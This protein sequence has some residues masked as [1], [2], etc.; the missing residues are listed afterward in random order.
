VGKG[1]LHWA[2][3]ND[4]RVVVMEAFNARN[5]RREDL[6]ETVGLGAIDVSFISLTKIL[7]AV[8]HVLAPRA[9]V[10]TLIKP[11][12]EAGRKEV[13]KGGVVRDASVRQRVVEDVRAFGCRETGLNWIGVRPSPL[14][15][16]A[17]NVEF[18]ALWEY[19][20]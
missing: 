8:T 19:H 4:P 15:G 18:L 6:P 9:K 1:Q 5:L 13:V 16:P 11:Q 14:K 17:G 7:P 12:F 3:R 2:L 20:G 10:I